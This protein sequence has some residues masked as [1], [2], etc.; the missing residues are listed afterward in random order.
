MDGASPTKVD[1]ENCDPAK[2]YENAT[3]CHVPPEEC[4]GAWFSGPW[5]E[6]LDLVLLF[7][8]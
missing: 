3:E 5:S 6:V 2:R 7:V 8:I 4:K 1:D